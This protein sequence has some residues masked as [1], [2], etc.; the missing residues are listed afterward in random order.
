MWHTADMALMRYTVQLGER[1][2]LVLPAVLR[3]ALGLDEGS[4]LVL[5]V[6]GETV[7]LMKAADVANA[8]R[9]L[10][11]RDASERDLVDELLAERRAEAEREAGALTGH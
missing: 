2:R 7:R 5:E 3:R 8:A 10:Y 1:G 4:Q 9:G 11:Q 6:E